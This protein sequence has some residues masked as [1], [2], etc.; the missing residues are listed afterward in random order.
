VS[1]PAEP[2]PPPDPDS[3]R[4]LSPAFPRRFKSERRER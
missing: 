2:I 3:R 4:S 1:A